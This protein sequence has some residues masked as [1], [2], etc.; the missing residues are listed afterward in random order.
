MTG[1]LLTAAARAARRDDKRRGLLRFLRQ[2]I[3][4]SQDVLQLVM[5]VD[6]PQAAHRTLTQ[7]ERDELVRRHTLDALGGRVTLW[8]ITAHGQAMAFDVNS[9]EPVRAVFE[10]SKISEQNVRHHLDV[11]RIR[12]KAEAAGWRD[13]VDG[14]RLGEVKVGKRPDAL[15]I[16]RD[17]QR[18]AIECERTMKTSKRYEQV[19]VNYLRALKA[20]E[21]GRVIWV[22][23]TADMAA[24]L[25]AIVTGIRTVK[26]AGQQVAIEP[27]RHHVKLFFTDYNKWPAV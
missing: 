8:G 15:A 18:C 13:W 3:W 5:G 9:E 25:K 7:L 17:G 12:L 27:E 23:P 1:N 24:R 10:P 11:Q 19:L 21:V 4:S 6:T 22:C 26:V 16:D 14:D 20:G 2:H